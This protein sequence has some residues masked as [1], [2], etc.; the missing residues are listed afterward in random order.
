M[1]T[2]DLI[3]ALTA[4]RRI[5]P[6]PRMLLLWALVPAIAFV[7]ILFF[8]RIGFRDDI[9]AALGTVRFLFKFVIVVPLALVTLGALFRSAGPVAT[10]GWW[11][12]LLPVPALLLCAG[13]A[14][15]LLSI[16]R[17]EWMTRLIGSNA[18]NCMTLI[19][20]LASGP[21]AIFIAA[22]KR[23]APADPGL[24][25]AIAGLAASAIAAV[26]YATNCFDDS[27][28]FVVT[29]YP[30]AIGVVVLAGYIAGRR[31]LRW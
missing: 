11:A 26:F 28:L 31:V 20:L 29:W 13:V 6:N 22:L 8:S 7:A 15:E 16:P 9:D 19:P 23:G 3:R 24:G 21:L 2:E 1:T 25:G 18:L 27:P 17:A 12:W 5:G 10:L 4:D 14:A 30:L